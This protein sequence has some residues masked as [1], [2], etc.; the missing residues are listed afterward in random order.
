MLAT[1][2]TWRDAITTN[3]P[4]HYVLMAIIFHLLNLIQVAWMFRLYRGAPNFGVF[5]VL[6]VCLF[7]VLDYYAWSLYR[8]IKSV[9][10][11][12]AQSPVGYLGYRLYLLALGFP[13][14]VM[15]F[16]NLLRR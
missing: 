4:R 9:P 7:A 1:N 8:H 5:L 15:G 10:E 11:E 6:L 13:F 3:N 16:F 12:S 14:V 2:N